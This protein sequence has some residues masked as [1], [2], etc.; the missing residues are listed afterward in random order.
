MEN[1]AYLLLGSNVGNRETYIRQAIHLLEEAGQVL[2][3]QS[4]C[5]ETAAW[6]LESQPDFLNQVISLHPPLTPFQL[7]ALLQQ[8]EGLLERQ[9]QQQYGPRTLDLDL[10]YYNDLVLD[11]PELVIPHPRLHLRR[12]T[13]V[14]LVEIAPYF[15][16]PVLERTHLEL[17][18]ACPDDKEVRLY[19]P[20]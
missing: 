3:L 18:E 19:G 7:L 10:L 20:A 13:L 5:Y 4:A 9:R 6:G 17:L 1:T 15:R 11:T 14:P 16:H 8:I 2:L 12:F